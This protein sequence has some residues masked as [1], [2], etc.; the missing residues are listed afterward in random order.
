MVELADTLGL[1]PSSRLAP[2]KDAFRCRFES[3]LPHHILASLVYI[4]VAGLWVYGRKKPESKRATKE[5]HKMIKNP[6]HSI[7]QTVYHNNTDCNTGN[8]IEAENLR[9][10]TGGKPL[11]KEC[12]DL[13]GK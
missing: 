1:D 9:Q 3:C 6:W 13:A 12:A 2:F 7:K 8:N 5:I 4:G 10:G 11:C